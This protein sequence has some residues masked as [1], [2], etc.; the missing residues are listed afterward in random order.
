[1]MGSGGMGSTIYIMG[2][3]AHQVTLDHAREMTKPTCSLS[4][5]AL[6]S[7]VLVMAL[8]GALQRKEPVPSGN[9]EE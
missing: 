9:A 4:I 2:P 5:A 1:M 3:T 8:R 6:L 7:G